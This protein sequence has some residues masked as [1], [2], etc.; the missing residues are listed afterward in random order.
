[1]VGHHIKPLN[2]QAHS[3]STFLP[4]SEGQ[5]QPLATSQHLASWDVWCDTGSIVNTGA[6]E[7][8]KY[9]TV[10]AAGNGSGRTWQMHRGWFRREMQPH[11]CCCEQT[12]PAPHDNCFQNGFNNTCQNA[13]WFPAGNCGGDTGHTRVRQLK[14]TCNKIQAPTSCYWAEQV[15]WP[16]GRNCT[17]L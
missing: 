15:V 6:N 17:S 11:P 3:T 12:C 4:A 5:G 1:M 2:R 14:L 10:S 8:E 13:T 9:T 7:Q 16:N